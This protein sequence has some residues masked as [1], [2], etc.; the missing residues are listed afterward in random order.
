M[1]QDD[2]S[3]QEHEP[4]FSEPEPPRQETPA[5]Y[6]NGAYF[7]AGAYALAVAG[8]LLQ[9]AGASSGGRELQWAGIGALGLPAAGELLQEIARYHRDGVLNAPKAAGSLLTAGGVAIAAG[10]TSVAGGDVVRNVAWA[11]QGV[12][13]AFRAVGEARNWESGVR[14]VIPP[15]DVEAAR[16]IP[17]ETRPASPPA[18]EDAVLGPGTGLT[19]R[20]AALTPHRPASGEARIADSTP[21]PRV[22]SPARGRSAGPR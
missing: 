14:P 6:W 11:V 17:G 3:R 19:S 18:D 10:A 8:P 22:V 1:N 20:A 7:K 9:T 4:D 5:P 13:L 16:G 15:A 12:G 2:G 21:A